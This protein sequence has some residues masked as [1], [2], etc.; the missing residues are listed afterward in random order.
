M[1]HVKEY[2]CL[3]SAFINP[4]SGSLCLPMYVSAWLRKSKRRAQTAFMSRILMIGDRPSFGEVQWLLRMDTGCSWIGDVWESESL[5]VSA[6]L[7]ASLVNGGTVDWPGTNYPRAI[8]HRSGD[9]RITLG[10]IF[11]CH[12]QKRDGH[13]HWGQPHVVALDLQWVW[14]GFEGDCVT[15]WWSSIHCSVDWDCA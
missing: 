5:S 13:N 6:S 12:P 3:L 4:R 9:T 14:R 15:S 8:C 11:S 1:V 7:R 2:P 10:H